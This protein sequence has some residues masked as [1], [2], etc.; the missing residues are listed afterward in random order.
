[1]ANPDI[2][3]PLKVD[4]QLPSATATK[5]QA[6]VAPEAVPQSS[7]LVGTQQNAQARIVE[8]ANARQEATV[9]MG[10]DAA[11]DEMSPMAAWRWFNSPDFKPEAGF[12]VGQR[13]QVLDTTLSTDDRAFLMKS[14]SDA[15]FDYRL[16]NIER[17]RAN[18][19]AIG[20]NP[21]TA[22]P[23]MMI[24]PAYLAV[25][26]ASLGAG[27]IA[28]AARL[29]R[30]VQRAAAGATA[31]A[32][33]LGI[34]AIEAQTRPVGVQE[35][36][37]NALINAGATA[38]VYNPVSRSLQPR[39]VEFPASVVNELATGTKSEVRVAKDVQAEVAEMRRT[40]VPTPKPD[41]TVA[42]KVADE[43]QPVVAGTDDVATYA[44]KVRAANDQFGDQVGT[45][46]ATL[47]RIAATKDPLMSGLAKRLDELMV[48]DIPVHKSTRKDSRSFYSPGRHLIAM[49]DGAPDWTHLHEIAHAVTA[50][51]L[52]FGRAQ[53]N[54]AIGGIVREIDNLHQRVAKKA[55]GKP[56]GGNAKYYLTNADEF[57]AGLFS[58]DKPFMDFLK[59]IPMEGTTVLG[60][61]VDL[62]RRVLGLGAKDENAL[63]R[64]MGL[65]EQLAEQPLRVRSQ[66][67]EKDGTASFYKVGVM[68][69]PEVPVASN[70]F[71]NEDATTTKLARNLSWSLHKSL[72]SYSAEAKKIADTLVDDPINMTG[73]SVVSQTRAIRADLAQYQYQY[74]DLLRAE[75]SKAGAGIRAQVMT[76][77]KALEAQQAIERRVMREMQ[78]REQAARQSLP[79]NS[80]E[81]KEIRAMADSLDQANSAALAEMK[82]AGVQGAEEVESSSG[83]VSR[84][85]DN[86][87]I[88]RMDAALAKQGMDQKKANSTIVSMLRTSLVRAN[89]WDQELAG[90]VA[91]AIIDRA[92]RKGYFEDTAFRG[93]AGN[94][95]L[96]ELRD[97]L[98][99]QGVPKDRMQRVLDLLAGKVDEAGKAP[100]LKHRVDLDY[101]HGI[102]VGG[103]RFTVGDL[104]G[105]DITR[106][107]EQYLDRVAGQSALARKGLG[108]V[109]ELGAM[110]T[111]LAH[112]VKSEAKRKEAVELFD[113]TIN[114]ILGRPVGE[115]IPQ[116]LRMSQAATRMVGLASSGLWQ[117]TE[118]APAMARY[119]ALRSLRYLAQ[120]MP[121]FG[122]MMQN[123][124]NDGSTA[125][126]LH[127]ILRRN[128][129]ADIRMRPFV[130][131]LEDNFDIPTSS[132]VQLALQQAQ[133]LV[134][135]LNAQKYVQTKQ[136]G[137]VANL[138]VDSLT[139]A[140]KG[141]KR[142]MAAWE[143]YGLKV[144]TMIRL[145]DEIKR[146]GT[147]TAKWSDGLW[148]EVRGPLTK[149][150][151]DSV[152]R[153][154]TGEIPAFAQFS[155]VGKFIFT[156]RSFVLGAHNKVLAG[157]IGREGFAGLGLLML[158]QMPLSML[159]TA[160][161]STM[162]GKE[163]KDEKELIAKS[164]G[165]MGSF[166]L[167]S[168]L[169]GVITGEKQQ[170][171]APGLILADR[172]YKTA[173]AAAQGN[174][175]AAAESAI[176]A[177]PILSII[178]GIRGFANLI[179]E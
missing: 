179:P 139:K 87:S 82:A 100:F 63:V 122:K 95:T 112:S 25:D 103:E 114:S 116:L 41:E 171:G 123:A 99:N 90:D 153:N 26:V 61:A 126:Q 170:F 28:A 55:K 22:T 150:M 117:I 32:G 120:E 19:Q 62:I 21:W 129:S 169:F 74:E 143:Q 2:H 34:T 44:R 6:Y 97:M 57:M 83:W 17:S 144:H 64:A 58:N 48:G 108:S 5:Q 164:F 159:A 104:L 16:G 109:S 1:M 175:G 60:K 20:D 29:G 79:W 178:P 7:I 9:G 137:M 77:G 107:Q 88:E 91:K 13:I 130:Q 35:F 37:T 166:G 134:P 76:P 174:F 56:L 149:A 31:G 50:H 141:D 140:G 59:S 115:D 111:E 89:G 125:T 172:I 70:L 106:I 152:L 66:V 158:Y 133:Q 155:Q 118:F 94:E 163:I 80:A 138:V 68:P 72:A 135:Y 96:A 148:A 67:L 45:A 128:A 8:Q 113:Q 121:G 167:F 15:E 131:R 14:K 49:R 38:A 36:V 33:A 92:R 52:E 54:T 53:P 161:N 27:R 18:F 124:T 30:G 165:Q 146:V 46:R 69:E 145:T 73:D 162:Q 39:D 168:D 142:A 105:T 132:R 11:I 98:Q 78:G 4:Y 51:R 136:A 3:D 160:V 157:T 176:S 42:P 10:V 47:A 71:A 93:H 86:D 101:R 156:F 12:S 154:R 102:N 75:M 173:G 65:T 177:T 24:D 151:D 84:R 147:D 110:R 23:L 81:S 119:G 40:E 85:W 127:S 43:V